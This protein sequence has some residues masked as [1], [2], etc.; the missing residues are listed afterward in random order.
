MLGDVRFTMF[1]WG[2]DTFLLGDEFFKRC[3]WGCG[4]QGLVCLGT[5]ISAPLYLGDLLGVDLLGSVRQGCRKD[6]G[7]L[8]F[9]ELIL[10]VRVGHGKREDNLT[11]ADPL[12]YTTNRSR[13]DLVIFMRSQ[14]GDVLA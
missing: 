14:A 7:Q 9:L 10:K 13:V 3:A 12:S 6:H 8:L 1:A 4:F 2:F 11:S 5:L